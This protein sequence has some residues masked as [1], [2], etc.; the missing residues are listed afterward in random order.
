MPRERRLAPHDDYHL[1]STLLFKGATPLTGIS[2]V[3]GTGQIVLDD[4][5]CTGSES[6]LVDCRHRGLLNHNC[7]HSEDAGVRCAS[8]IM[9]DIILCTIIIIA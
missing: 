7:D 9:L 1:S 6:R 5:R 4:L 8:G 3:D 2:T